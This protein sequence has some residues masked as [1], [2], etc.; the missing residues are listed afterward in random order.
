MDDVMFSYSEPYGGVTLRNSSLTATRARPTPRVWYRLRPI[1][2]DGWRHAG[3]E[4]A[5][6]HCP[7]NMVTRSFVVIGGG[8]V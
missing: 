1:L 4:F 6:H 5:M 3:P 8:C 2:D 7:V